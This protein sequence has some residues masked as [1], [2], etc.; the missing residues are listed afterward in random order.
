ML[1]R[2]FG[3]PS[4]LAASLLVS[5]CKSKPQEPAPAPAAPAPASTGASR[6]AEWPPVA[7]DTLS[8]AQQTGGTCRWVRLDAGSGTRREVFTFEGGCEFAQFAWSHDG[9]QGAVLQSFEDARPPRAW[10]V[11]FLSSQ[12]TALAL[13][14]VGRATE[15]GFDAEGRPVALVAHPAPER[16]EEEGRTSFVF[17][18]GKYPVELQ[19]GD[20]G[21]AH[22][23]RRE[24]SAWKRVQTQVTSF[25]G[26]LARETRV[27]E[28]AK[29]LGP[30]TKLDAN[31]GPRSESVSPEEQE[32]LDATA[33]RQP[34][35]VG[36]RGEDIAP[37]NVWV[38]LSLPGGPVYLKEEQ[39]ELLSQSLPLRWRVGGK[40]VEPEKLALPAD[41]SISLASQG[42]MLLVTSDKAVRLYD[43][44]QKK[45]LLSLE[46]AS[47]PRFWPRPT[48]APGK[49]GAWSLKLDDPRAA[50][51]F[52]EQSPLKL[53]EGGESCAQLAEAGTLGALVR[54]ARAEAAAWSVQ[55]EA[56]RGTTRW[57]CQARFSQRGGEDNPDGP[58]MLL[59]YTVD[60]TSRTIP[61]D[62]LVCQ[63]AG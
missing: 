54:K 15:L 36:P 20:F 53:Q 37:S 42:P 60:D 39:T 23:Y 40:L 59:R 34:E 47:A 35:L 24:G 5:A 56:P 51:D 18:G 12:G 19:E 33:P 31:A 4:L 58:A 57:A 16:V 41:A 50:L 38:R 3:L 9:R 10:T 48:A 17:E 22:A 61:P 2:P 49:P 21:L 28:L 43:V 46:G 8:F 44:K 27:L 25:G 1:L 63:M 11:D 14:E 62:S 55:C 6:P 52:L 13:P 45:H 29:R 26:D 7:D 30:H 32:A